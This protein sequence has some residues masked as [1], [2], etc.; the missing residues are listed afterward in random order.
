MRKPTGRRLLRFRP[1]ERPDPHPNRADA[2]QQ[3]V[4][5]LLALLGSPARERG[6]LAERL[7]AGSPDMAILIN[8]RPR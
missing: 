2:S 1:H 8:E 5:A 6:Q 4:W 3:V 7:A